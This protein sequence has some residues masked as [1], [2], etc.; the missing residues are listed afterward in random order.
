MIS[1]RTKLERSIIDFWHKFKLW[2]LMFRKDERYKDYLQAQFTRSFSKKD[3][4]INLRTKLLVDKIVDLCS[5][6]DAPEVLGVGCR[7]T[8]E[9][10]DFRKKV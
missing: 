6:A 3:H 9:L 4:E 10:E 5:F 8:Q 2:L 7:N 1:I